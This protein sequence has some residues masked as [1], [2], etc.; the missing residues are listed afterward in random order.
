M[1]LELKSAEVAAI[2]SLWKAW[3]T[4]TDSEL[5]ATFRKLDY[6]NFLNIVKYLRSLGLTESPQP[7]KLNIL[8]AS[9]LRFSL[10]GS[11]VI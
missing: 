1:S 7:P 3:S 10:V 6:T 2:D 4:S 5:E 11:G 9:G 8:T